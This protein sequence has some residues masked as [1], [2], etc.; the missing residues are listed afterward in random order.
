MSRVIVTQTDERPAGVKTTVRAWA[1]ARG[2]QVKGNDV[3]LKPNLNT[4]D[5]TPGSTHNQ[6]LAALIDELW[7]M[8]AKSVTLGERSWKSTRGVLAQK[9]LEPLLA[10]KGVG[11]IV[12]DELPEKDWILF[13]PPGCHW[14]EGFRIAR[15]MVE[16]ECLV[17]TCCLKTHGFG[18]VFTLS[19]K[20]AVGSAPGREQMTQYMDALHSSPHQRRMIAELNTAFSPA[21]TLL[22]GVDAFVDGGPATG[23]RAK[24]NVFL[25][26]ADRVAL[27]ATGVACLRKLGSNEAIMTTPVFQHEQLIRAAELGL[28]ASSADEVELIPGDEASAD[29]ARELGGILRED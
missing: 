14:P 4:A 19:L 28:G 20:L 26:A 25:A 11:L 1:K 12:F 21:F 7:D 24:G 10:E 6:T 17:Q 5:L 15:P 27:D 2:N 9:E 23:T 3:L 16:A 29:L 18:G 8:G 13:N 22:D